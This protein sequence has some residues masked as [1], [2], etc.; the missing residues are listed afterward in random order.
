MRALSVF[1]FLLFSILWGYHLAAGGSILSA[2]GVVTGVLL[3]LSAGASLL[4][5]GDRYVLD[6]G[7]ISYSNPILSRLGLRLERRVPWPDVVSVRAHRGWSHGFRESAPS[8][9]FLQLVTGGRFV[10]D[11]VDE[12]EEVRRL[13]GL[14]VAG[15]GRAVPPAAPGEGP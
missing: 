13:V 10:I 15:S 14:H 12:M 9:L 8:A 4:N 5:L 3:L 11:S 2:G 7:G 1:S 6:E